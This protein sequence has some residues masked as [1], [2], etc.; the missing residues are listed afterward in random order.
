MRTI[1][2]TLPLLMSAGLSGCATLK[3]DKTVCPE[4]RDL[5]CATAPEC[6]MDAERGCRV[7]QC[8]P[9]R[10]EDGKLPTG[11]PPDHR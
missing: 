4:Y 10:T 1:A 5:R 3:S 6:S 8:A 11:V 7:C 2:A 9:S